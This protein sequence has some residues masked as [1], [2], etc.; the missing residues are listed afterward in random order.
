MFSILSY[1]LSTL[2]VKILFEENLAG[3]LY[4]EKQGQIQGV[5]IKTT[6]QKRRQGRL[7]FEIPKIVKSVK[8]K[9]AQILSFS[10]RT[11]Q[12]G[13][14]ILFKICPSINIKNKNL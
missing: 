10:G 2:L 12:H 5:Q 3:R 8:Q 7:W 11:Q 4:V 6:V 14:F 9:K 13:N 1:F